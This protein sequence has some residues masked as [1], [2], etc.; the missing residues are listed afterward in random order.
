MKILDEILQ[1][2][3][4]IVCLVSYRENI[5]TKPKLGYECMIVATQRNLY[6]VWAEDHKTHVER[7]L[8]EVRD[9]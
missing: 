8:F 2:G 5:G 4:T 6:K 9:A 7:I 3:E 1:P